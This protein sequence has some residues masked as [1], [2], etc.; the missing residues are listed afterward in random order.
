MKFA[1]AIW[2]TDMMTPPLNMIIFQIKKMHKKLHS[3]IA[4]IIKNNKKSG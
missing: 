4:I 2:T 1:R 3:Y